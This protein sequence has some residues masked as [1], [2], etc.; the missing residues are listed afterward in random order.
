MKRIILIS[1]L[2]LGISVNTNSQNSNDPIASDEEQIE[3]A[4]QGYIVNFFLNKYDEMEVHLHEELSKRGVNGDGKLNENVS[5]AELKVMM[6][7]KQVLP[8]SAQKNVVSE[9]KIDKRV[10]TAILDTGYPRTRWKEY[11]HLAKLDGNW[12]IMDVFWCFEKIE[13]E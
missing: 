5:K 10:A 1:L 12:V 13:G 4:I 2:T 9:I 3:A 7:N 8:L 6:Q 11:F